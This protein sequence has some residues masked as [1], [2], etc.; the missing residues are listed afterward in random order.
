MEKHIKVA[1][2]L[3]E[4]LENRFSIFGFRFG[5]DPILG[6]FVGA[7][8]AVTAMIALYVVWIAMRMNLPTEKIVRML[9]NI[10]LDLAIGFIPVF[11]DIADFGFKSNTRNLEILKSHRET[12]VQS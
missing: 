2:S 10:A 11:G 5:L 6:L 7:G 3:V 8:D 12:V 4:L 1:T 9:G